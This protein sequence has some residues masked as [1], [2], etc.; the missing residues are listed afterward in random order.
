MDFSVTRNLVNDKYFA[1]GSLCNA[2]Q[3]EAA[4]SSPGRS[5]GVF[6]V[7]PEPLP[8]LANLVTHCITGW[9]W[10]ETFY[11][12]RDL[13]GAHRKGL[14]LALW[15]CD[16]WC[17]VSRDGAGL[18]P[19]QGD[20]VTTAAREPLAGPAHGP[21]PLLRLSCRCP[22]QAGT[23][24]EVSLLTNARSVY[25][26]SP[27]PTLWGRSVSGGHLGSL[28]SPHKILRGTPGGGRSELGWNPSTASCP[29]QVPS[30]TSL[31]LSFSRSKLMGLNNKISKAF[32][33]SRPLSALGIYDE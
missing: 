17:P 23:L 31:H 5:C 15:P 8:S 22:G 2:A 24:L 10:A 3:G 18:S 16:L 30:V 21:L 4:T 33:K 27:V 25:P 20:T 6:R 19:V 7:S 13:K 28:P 1:M 12:E 14:E 11:P 26:S 9:V 32:S 29:K